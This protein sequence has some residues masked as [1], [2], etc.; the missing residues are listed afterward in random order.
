MRYMTKEHD[1]NRRKGKPGS[2]MTV[3]LVSALL[4]SPLTAF[5]A[6]PYDNIPEGLTEERYEQLCDDTVE[7]DEIE[8]LIRYF[9]PT[10]SSLLEQANSTLDDI[11]SSTAE[12]II[13]Y[14]DLIKQTEEGL[15]AAYG[16]L[17]QYENTL[18][19]DSSVIQNLKA[20]IADAELNKAQLIEGLENI[21]KTNAQIEG[22]LYVSGTQTGVTSRDAIEIQLYPV[23]EQLRSVIEGL[24]ISYGQLSASRDIY[25]QQADLYR[26]VL[27]M[28]ESMLG[29][30]LATQAEVAQARNDLNV[31]Q[32]TLAQTDA[33]LNQLAEAIGLQLGYKDRIPQIGPAPD[34]DLS[35]VENADLAADIV[36]AGGENTEIR[37][38]YKSDGTTAGTALRDMTYNEAMGKLSSRMNELYADMKEK[39]VLYE[40]S[41]ATLKKAELTL[42]GAQ[43]RYE[44]GMLG[45]SEYKAQ[46]L[47]YTSY[48]VSAQLAKSNLQQSIN[49]YRWAVEGVLSLG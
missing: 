39:A 33:S 32:S 11:Q 22:R 13:N 12:D 36:R 27:T 43:T 8:D 21:Y 30:G 3:L 16:L 19:A 42:S 47:T 44:L 38:A 28:Q 45:A 40:A 6:P 48:M 17:A 35:Y 5:G 29:L 7:W 23:M 10:Y 18:P 41:Q 15:E 4:S 46:I 2:L 49:N 14:P 31:A 25:A 34:P 20:N 37:S 1:H 24:V 9:S 26:S